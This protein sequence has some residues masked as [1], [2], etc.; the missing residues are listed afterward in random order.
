MNFT[1]FIPNAAFRPVLIPN[2]YYSR[3]TR[4]HR[5]SVRLTGTDWT[6]ESQIDRSASVPAC[7]AAPCRQTVILRHAEFQKPFPAPRSTQTGRLRAIFWTKSELRTKFFMI[8]GFFL[9]D[10]PNLQV[11]TDVRR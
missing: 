11:S 5:M 6:A 1:A 9:P 8:P 7:H 4:A 2:L 3:A 10:S